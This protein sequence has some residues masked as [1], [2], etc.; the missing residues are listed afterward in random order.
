MCGFVCGVEC[1]FVCRIVLGLSGLSFRLYYVIKE[2]FSVC[3][4]S[5]KKNFSE[6]SH[7]L[8]SSQKDFSFFSV[9]K[10]SVSSV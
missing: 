5:L 7:Y 2:S 10:E 1:G 9:I 3:I 4:T 6:V 8:T